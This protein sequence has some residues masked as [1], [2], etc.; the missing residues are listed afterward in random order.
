MEVKF[1]EIANMVHRV[2]RTSS[3]VS[4]KSLLNQLDKKYIL[5]ILS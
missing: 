5:P 4:I 1:M 2:L 3:N